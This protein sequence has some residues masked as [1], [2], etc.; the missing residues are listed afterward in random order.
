MYQNG[1]AQQRYP[2]RSAYAGLAPELSDEDRNAYIASGK[3]IT[4]LGKMERDGSCGLERGSVYGAAVAIPQIARSSGWSGTMSALAV[5]SYMFLVLN[6]IL[7]LFLL[8][9][10][11]E[12]EILGSAFAGK[13]H[14]CDFG[15][16]ME[17]CP[18][19]AQNCRGPGGTTISAPRLYSFDVWSTRVYIRDSL[20]ALF[21][22]RKEEISEIVD[23]GEYG[24]E[25]YYC[26]AACCFIF[27][28][29]MMDD[30]HKT[31]GLAILL[32][33]VPSDRSK[34]VKYEPPSW[35]TREH[36]KRVHGWCELD[37]VKYGV[38][39]MP[40]R[41]KIANLLF[42]FVPK[43]LIWWILATLGMHFLMETAG[44]VDSIMNSMALT[45]VI[46]LDEMIFIV[47]TTV[48][49]KH[50]MDNL[51][52]HAL[53]NLE[54]EEG[55]SEED[56]LTRYMRAEFGSNK[57]KSFFNLLL[58]K[59]LLMVLLLMAA[60]VWNYYRMNCNR[61]EDGSLVSKPMRLP[62][63][64]RFNPIGLFTERFQA[65]EDAYWTMPTGS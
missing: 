61:A 27:M 30:L 48:P 53:F 65:E 22:D 6:I 13:V 4:Y 2:D 45:F 46:N 51:E 38:G 56:T 39:G 31:L 50:M 9:M 10:I 24:I 41:W 7:Q 12:S 55:E 21:A 59:R 57:W 14:L 34:W 32:W 35:A 23:P 47:F 8:C 33:H 44:I 16:D 26:R 36:A 15:A 62:T 58:P 17:K 19:E 64:V 63:V 18:A 11:A 54:S 3:A 25:N 1:S 52:D 37:L 60:F 28:M 49:V 42:V 20:V 43:I 5:R 40:F 29:G